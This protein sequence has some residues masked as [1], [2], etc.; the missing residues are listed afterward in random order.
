MDTIWTRLA[1]VVSRT[2][3][4]VFPFAAFELE[5]VPPAGA[6]APAAARPA[7]VVAPPAPPAP[8]VA[9]AAP[10]PT[11]YNIVE[12]FHLVVTSLAGKFCHRLSKYFRYT[13]IMTLWKALCPSDRK[14]L[15]ALF[16]KWSAGT[17]LPPPPPSKRQRC[18][19]ID[20]YKVM[21]KQNLLTKGFGTTWSQH[22]S[23]LDKE[24]VVLT[25]LA[26]SL[27]GCSPVGWEIPKK[28]MQK[29]LANTDGP[30]SSG[31]GGA[32]ASSAASAG[33]RQ[34]APAGSKAPSMK[35]PA[36]STA[37]SDADSSDK[38][39]SASWRVQARSQVARDTPNA[40]QGI[41]FF[42]S[43]CNVFFC[44]SSAL[45]LTTRAPSLSR[46]ERLGW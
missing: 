17:S 19:H 2:P 43:V 35:R 44:H 36:R 15:E 21:L 3:D 9:P 14:F 27:Q 20:E 25:A 6:P 7:P 31:S 45:C 42:L 40:P 41:G 8:P 22:C 1:Y 10:A 4:A 23:K 39:V 24:L 37:A 5:R 13:A 26:K 12:G 18:S 46:P 28:F 11:R 30:A 34:K 29:Y 16:A 33:S 38:S 32:A